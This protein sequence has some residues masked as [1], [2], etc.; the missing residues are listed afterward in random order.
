MAIKGSLA[1]ASLPEVIRLLSYSLRS[2][3]LSVT[4]GANLGSIF[5][6]EGKIIYATIRKRK[7]RIGTS[8]LKKQL[9]GEEMLDRALHMQKEKKGKRI[10]E[11]LVEMGVISRPVLERELKEQI[12]EALYEMLTWEKGHFNFEVGFLPSSSEQTTVLSSEDLLLGGARL[13]HDWQKIEQKLPGFDTVLSVRENMKDFNL[14]ESEQKVLSFVNGANSVDQIVKGSGLTYHD[15]CRVVYVLLAAGV[16][17]KA[18]KPASKKPGAVDVD[19]Y[20]STALAFYQGAQYDDAEREFKKIAEIQPDHTEA[21]FYLGLI[22]IARHNDEA[23]RQYL[24]GAL[25]RENQISI[26]IDLGFICSRMGRFEEAIGFLYRARAQKPDSIKTLLNLGIANYRRGELAEAA[27][28]FERCLDL[29]ESLITPVLYLSAIHIRNNEM[30]KATGLFTRATERFPR[31]A[32]FKNNLALL[33]EMA[34]RDEDAENLYRQVLATQPDDTAV[35][36]NLAGLYYRLGIYGG[37]RQYYEQIPEKD[38][39]LQVAVNLGRL[40]LLQGDQNR[41]RANW[42]RAL[43]LNP[44]DQRLARD[45]EIMGDLLPG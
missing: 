3:C 39:D 26:L 23:A 35:L 44:G 20:K 40:C 11:I 9:F 33:H 1:E 19:A 32:A 22:E 42:E 27:R 2:G 45:I 15:A 41:A 14:A 18:E 28:D 34:G 31:F 7:L 37:A 25:A 24:E 16:V 10:G 43:A 12:E 6:K 21:L 5:L 29:S 13:M 36:K 17:E 30:D 4:D 8:L 38:R